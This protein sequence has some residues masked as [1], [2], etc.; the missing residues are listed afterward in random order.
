[1]ELLGQMAYA[2]ENFIALVQLP[3]EEA[4]RIYTPTRL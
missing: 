3:S 4:E 1:M 2:F